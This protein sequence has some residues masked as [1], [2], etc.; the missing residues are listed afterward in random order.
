ILVRD[1]SDTD[2]YG[3]LLRNIY[4]QDGTFVNAAL[5]EQGFAHVVI[6][7]PDVSHHPLLLALQDEA[8]EAGVGLWAPEEEADGR[9]TPTNASAADLPDG[10]E[11]R[12]NRIIDGDTIDVWLDGDIYRV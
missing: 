3:R 10:E 7:P 4:L 6:F 2:P 1:V 12:V 11:A 8:R 5:I 9:A